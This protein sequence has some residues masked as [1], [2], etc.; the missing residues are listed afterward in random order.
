MVL[1]L[2]AFAFTA[3]AAMLAVLEVAHLSHII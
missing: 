3:I 1:Q 2:G